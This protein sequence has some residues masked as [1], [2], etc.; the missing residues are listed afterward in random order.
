MVAESVGKNPV[1]I[2]NVYK[3]LKDADLL[4]VQ[5]GVGT[6]ELIRPA[7]K[8]TLW[9]IYKAVETDQ[10]DEIFKFP[11]TLSGVCTVGG[12]IRELL[13]IHYFKA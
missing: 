12:S 2:R 10:I 8:I 4:S 9:D 13:T 7:S 5:R 11:E 3:K 1:I 6:T